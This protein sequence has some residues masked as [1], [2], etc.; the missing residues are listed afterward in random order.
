M[1]SNRKSLEEIA[2]TTAAVALS[3][4][5][6]FGTRDWILPRLFHLRHADVNISDAS[7]VIINVLLV[8]LGIAFL[9]RFIQRWDSNLPALIGGL[10]EAVIAPLLDNVSLD[11]FISSFRES[12]P[13]IAGVAAAAWFG[14]WLASKTPIVRASMR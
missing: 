10:A 13:V 4:F 1:Q 14:S 11:W 7:A 2:N 8:P 3:L 6:L 5:A 9:L 12:I